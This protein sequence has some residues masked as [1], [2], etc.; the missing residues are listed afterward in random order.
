MKFMEDLYNSTTLGYK[1]N[2]SFITLVL[3]NSSPTSINEYRPISLVSSLYKIIAK[4]FANW[5]KTVIREV[6]SDN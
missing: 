3:K 6:I 5:L 4:T 1:V 2:S